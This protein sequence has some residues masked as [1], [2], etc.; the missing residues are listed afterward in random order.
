MQGNVAKCQGD[1]LWFELLYCDI[2]K[3]AN[4][5]RTY[6]MKWWKFLVDILPGQ[7]GK[8]IGAKLKD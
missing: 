1:S 6:S 4:C 2:L 5:R 3:N 8:I 7:F